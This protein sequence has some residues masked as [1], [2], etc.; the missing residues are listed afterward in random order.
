MPKLRVCPFSV[1]VFFG[2]A[3]LVAYHKRKQQD[4]DGSR[5]TNNNSS[6][7]S[8]SMPVC[9]VVF[10][11]GAPGVG[12]GTQC[13]LLTERLTKAKWV[14]LSAGDLLRA[15]RQSGS[16]LANEI[17]DCIAQGKLVRSEITCQLLENAMRKAYES[18]GTTHFLVDGYPRSRENV[19]AWQKT[20]KHHIIQFVLDYECPE[21]TLIGRLLERGKQSGR[22]DDN[23]EVVK[24][25]FAT[26][27]NETAPILDYYRNST[28][29][30]V[31]TIATDK[32]VEEV[33]KET[34]RYF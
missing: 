21:E 7:S 18:D 5:S 31:H 15:E 2:T 8:S 14:H 33:Y 22:T 20:M 25:R 4:D 6:S 26:F 13:Q 23:L 32:G 30:P 24:K 9:K 10:V 12:K 1:A 16:A 19:D 29:V 34:K 3:A 17:N 11:L 28:S 27:Q